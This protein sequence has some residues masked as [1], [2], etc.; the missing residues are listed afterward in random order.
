MGKRPLHELFQRT[1]TP[2]IVRQAFEGQDEKREYWIRLYQETPL[3]ELLEAAKIVTAGKAPQKLEKAG[4]RSFSLVASGKIQEEENFQRFCALFRRLRKETELS[5]RLPGFS[6]SS[7]ALELKQ[8]GVTRYHNNLESCADFFPRLC[9]TH[10]QKGKCATL[11]IAAEAELFLCSRGII[12]L[13][14]TPVHRIALALELR[15][16]KISSIPLNVLM[17]HSRNSFGKEPPPRPR[18]KFCVP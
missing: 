14:E 4:G 9:S 5:L 3:E 18:R 16:L 13:G 6:L 8:A 12:G 2:F 11:K 7:K 1:S 17:P 15:K 10:G